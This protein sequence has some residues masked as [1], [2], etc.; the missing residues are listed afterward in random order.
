MAGLVV[1]A[2]IWLAPPLAGLVLPEPSWKPFPTIVQVGYIRPEPIEHIRFL[3][4]VAAPF[5]LLAVWLTVRGWRRSRRRSSVVAT[6]YVLVVQLLI[7]ALAAVSWVAQRRAH[8]WFDDRTL[9]VAV[10]L[11]VALF[12]LT[13]RGWVVP[14][15]TAT[16]G[17]RGR[18]LLG[19]GIA[20]VLTGYWLLPAVF[21][22]ANAV[23]VPGSFGSLSQIQFVQDEL[24]SVLNGRTPMVDFASQYAKL[25]PF[26]LAPVLAALGPSVGVTT[27]VL[28]VLGLFGLLAVYGTFVVLTE[29]A[30]AALV[31]YVPFLA[32]T[33]FTFQNIG[34]ERINLATLFGVVPIRVL[35]PFVLAWLCARQLRKGSGAARVALFAGAG[36]VAI[37]NT[38]YGA[39]AF[40]ALGLALWCGHDGQRSGWARART[41]GAQA[42]AGAAS[43]ALA[44][45]ALT[46]IR[47]GSLPDPSIVSNLSRVFAVEGFGMEPMPT[48]GLH[49]IIYLTFV[50]SLLAG[51]IGAVR[52]DDVSPQA[53]VQRGLLAYSGLFGLGASAY[54]VGR[55]HP[56]ALFGM[57]PTWGLSVAILCW[58]VLRRVAARPEAS[59]ATA[60]RWVLPATGVLMAFG[61]MMTAIVQ[62]PTPDSQLRRFTDDGPEVPQ[63]AARVDFIA[64]HT[65]RGESVAVLAPVGHLLAR[66]AGI[67]NVSPY[68]S[69][70]SIVFYEQMDLLFGVMAKSAA[71]KVFVGPTWPETSAYLAEKGFVTVASDPG[72]QLT[73]WQRPPRPEG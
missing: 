46:L 23:N 11:G 43:S 5:A 72:S 39:A 59:T 22:T 32:L 19:T 66:D 48:F 63:Y 25:L 1:A 53:R 28:A 40:I 47:A 18:R 8:Q 37:N 36:L 55:S 67:V 61:L 3:M 68:A 65:V 24:A 71:T 16:G 38:E 44:V 7:A 20:V 56:L 2:I 70:A 17:G 34:D 6:W 41:L 42:A 14:K 60:V 9:L 27:G 62:I 57:F 26:A 49:I 10:V 30:F 69:E 64:A 15:P 73:A 33:L 51:V 21:R 45:C 50:V 4:A 54:W 31:L 29:D 13:W 12:A 35:G 52:S 58:A